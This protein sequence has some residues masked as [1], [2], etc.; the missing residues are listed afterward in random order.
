M[1]M[2]RLSVISGS[3]TSKQ[4][5][6]LLI[7]SGNHCSHS[8]QMQINNFL[9]KCATLEGCVRRR[10]HAALISAGKDANELSAIKL[11]AI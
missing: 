6:Y 7:Q 9:S 10:T 2:G 4:D 8:W 5:V 3:V 11:Y 1:A